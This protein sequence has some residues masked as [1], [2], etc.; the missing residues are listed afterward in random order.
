[1]EEDGLKGIG[2]SMLF[3]A[4]FCEC[5]ITSKSNYMNFS[6]YVFVAT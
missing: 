1:M 6:L 2:E 3:F 4:T 5:V